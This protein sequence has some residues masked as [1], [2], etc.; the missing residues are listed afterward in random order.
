MVF[1]SKWRYALK[2]SSLHLSFIRIYFCQVEQAKIYT[3]VLFGEHVKARL[4][5]KVN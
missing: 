4:K 3:T 5:S 1:L 2:S